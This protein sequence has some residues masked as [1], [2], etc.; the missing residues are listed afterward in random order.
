MTERAKKKNNTRTAQP[1]GTRNQGRILLRRHSCRPTGVWTGRAT[2]ITSEPSS[3]WKGF[4]HTAQWT[5]SPTILSGTCRLAPQ[6]GQ[7]VTL[8]G[9]SVGLWLGAGGVGG[10]AAP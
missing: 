4:P 2:W 3:T 10:M 5:T 7:R 6:D 9:R 8:V 1:T